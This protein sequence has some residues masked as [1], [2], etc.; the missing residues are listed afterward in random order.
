MNFSGTNADYLYTLIRQ[1][2]LDWSFFKDVSLFR[3]DIHYS[4]KPNSVTSNQ[5]VKNFLE[6]TYN[7]IGTKLEQKKSSF[8]LNKGPYILKIGSLFSSNYYRVYEKDT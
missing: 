8:D 5:L 6:S 7:R 3:F 1:R 4:Y 2:K